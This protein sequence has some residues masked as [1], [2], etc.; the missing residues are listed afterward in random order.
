M[1]P[2]AWSALSELDLHT[3]RPMGTDLFGLAGGI[4]HSVFRDKDPG[5]RSRVIVTPRGETIR[6]Q[7]SGT[8]GSAIII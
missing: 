4:N 3:S 8:A 2:K 7:G 1:R 5:K 6:N